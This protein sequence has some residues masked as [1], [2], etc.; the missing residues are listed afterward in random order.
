MNERKEGLVMGRS[1]EL[2]GIFELSY[3][4]G[5]LTA[6][7]A[8]MREMDPDG[9][10]DHIAKCQSRIDDLAARIESKQNDEIFDRC[11]VS[12]DTTT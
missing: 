3:E 2:I 7:V 8:R 11:D 1:E 10:Q 6:H 9:N 4:I 5:R 12:G